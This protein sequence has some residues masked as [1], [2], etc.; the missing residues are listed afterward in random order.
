MRM[1][2]LEGVEWRLEKAGKVDGIPPPPQK[3]E[4]E[5]DDDGRC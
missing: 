5:E 1:V 2:C 3:A 4:E